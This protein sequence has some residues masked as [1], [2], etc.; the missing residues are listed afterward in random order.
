MTFPDGPPQVLAIYI[1]YVG[2]DYIR[3]RINVFIKRK[4]KK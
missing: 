1:G 2:T 4:N 3:A